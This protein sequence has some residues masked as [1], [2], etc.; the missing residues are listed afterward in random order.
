MTTI[1]AVIEMKTPA[2][3]RHVYR[4]PSTLPV[5]PQPELCRAVPG[6]TVKTGGIA[7]A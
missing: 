5:E 3:S 1:A 6:R 2:A 7:L 4:P